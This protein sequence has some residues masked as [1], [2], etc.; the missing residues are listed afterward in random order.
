MLSQTAPLNRMLG[1]LLREAR[2]AVELY[3]E[4]AMEHLFDVLTEMDLMTEIKGILHDLNIISCVTH[5]QAKVIKP[6]L[7]DMLYQPLDTQDTSFHDVT[8][9]GSQVEELQKSAQSVYTAVGD[10]LIRCLSGTYFNS[11]KI[12]WI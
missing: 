8:R 11:C 12:C 4:T 6:F 5:Q 7:R 2:T 3:T 9:L 10:A 1:N